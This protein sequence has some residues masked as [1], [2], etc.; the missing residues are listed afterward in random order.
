MI[1]RISNHIKTFDTIIYLISFFNAFFFSILSSIRCNILVYVFYIC[2][3]LDLYQQNSEKFFYN[4]FTTY[5]MLN[6]RNFA[7]L[8]EQINI[9]VPQSLFFSLAFSLRFISRIKW[10]MRYVDETL[11]STASGPFYILFRHDGWIREWL[12]CQERARGEKYYYAWASAQNCSS[13]YLI[14]I[15]NC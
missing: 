14:C 4:I 13:T 9:I 11:F 10:L 8:C 7:V 5:Q 1:Y 12:F 3:F 15:N 2:F 6:L